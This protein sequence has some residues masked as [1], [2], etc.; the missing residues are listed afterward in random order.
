MF[1]QVAIPHL[2][3][4]SPGKAAVAGEVADAV[5]GILEKV[6]PTDDGFPGRYSFSMSACGTMGYATYPYR[7]KYALKGFE[8]LHA[9]VFIQCYS[10]CIFQICINRFS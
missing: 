7:Q 6:S 1:L 9:L 2:S 3:I 5:L 4:L 10:F 8:V